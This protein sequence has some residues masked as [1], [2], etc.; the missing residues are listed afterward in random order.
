MSSDKKQRTPD[1]I[2]ADIAMKR[3]AFKAREI[4]RE[5]GTAVVIAENE[6]IGK[7]ILTRHPLNAEFR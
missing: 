2:N 4:A 3:A 5:T 1:L 6:V 7:N